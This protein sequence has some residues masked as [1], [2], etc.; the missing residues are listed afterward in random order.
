MHRKI[1][2]AAC[3]VVEEDDTDD[4]CDDKPPKVFF[5]V[6]CFKGMIVPTEKSHIVEY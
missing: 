5:N 2:L 1:F 3:V 4:E 6:A